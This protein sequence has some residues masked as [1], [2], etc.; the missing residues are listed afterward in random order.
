MTHN[1]KR[2]TLITYR[3]INDFAFGRFS[4]EHNEKGEGIIYG[5]LKKDN[6]T[7]SKY[8]EIKLCKN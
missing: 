6:Q 5:I 2:Y 8:Q 4:Y 3:S 7:R 1:K